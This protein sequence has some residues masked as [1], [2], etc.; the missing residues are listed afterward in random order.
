GEPGAPI[1]YDEY[2]DSSEEIG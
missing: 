1:D 2:G